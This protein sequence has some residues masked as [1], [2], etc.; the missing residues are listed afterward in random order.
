MAPDIVSHL[1]PPRPHVTLSLRSAPLLTT[2][3]FL[4]LLLVPCA[5]AQNTP[6]DLAGI[7]E[8]SPYNVSDFDAVNVATGSLT[9]HIPLL[10]YPQRGALKVE[11]ELL[12]NG[13]MAQQQTS[14]DERLGTC[15]PPKYQPSKIPGPGGSYLPHGVYASDVSNAGFN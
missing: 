6:D 13:Q 10:S 7:R 12:Y 14:C 11:Y 4:V 15:N 5:V 3:A 9:L 1:S 8:G 2:L